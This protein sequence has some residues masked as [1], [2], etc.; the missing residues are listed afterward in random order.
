MAR[1]RWL[2]Y[3]VA[4]MLVSFPL[5]FAWEWF[6]CQPYFVHRATPATAASMLIAT[7]GDLVLT[8]VAYAVVALLRG[9]E[10]PLQRWCA[11][12]SLTL[13]GTAL[14]LA[15]TTEGYAL[16]T[17]RWTYTDAAP[18]VPGTPISMLPILQSLL[19][20]PASFLTARIIIER[21]G[22]AW[23]GDQA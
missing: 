8:L 22:R 11:S 5:H 9:P 12:P 1:A 16:S 19:L 10:W 20:L 6:Q 14:V 15:F 21:F 4:L 23:P 13:V 18:L 17:G 2:A 7:L 3:L